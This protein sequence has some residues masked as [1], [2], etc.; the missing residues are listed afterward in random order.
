MEIKVQLS[1]DDSSDWD[2]YVASHPDSSNYHLHGWRYVIER[3]FGH[4][5]YYLVA[6]KGDGSICGVLPLAFMKSA[7]FGKFL[8]SLPFFNYG[9]VLA[10]SADVEQM[11]I[12]GAGRLMAQLCAAHVELRHRET[13]IASLPAKQHKVTMILSLESSAEA[14]WKGFN[15]K[16]RNQIR[17]AE[18]SGLEA[19]FG[20]IELLDGFYEVFTRNMRD[21]GTPVYAKE[22]FRN[23]LNELPEAT[24]IVAV[25]YEGKTIAA[26]IATW[27]RD[28]IE[29]PWASSISDYKSMCP[30]NMLYWEAIKL[31]I[32]KGISWFDFGRSTPDEG[33]FNFKKQ[34]GAKPVQLYWQYLLRDGGRLPELNTKNPKFELAIKVW[35]RLPLML[36]NILGPRI[37]KNIP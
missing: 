16:L 29:I 1:N 17:K 31:A 12:E 7:I 32:E 24:R 6:R 28:T 25:V 9:G 3:S 4:K 33:T 37:V 20:G 11:L 21:L 19:Q 35:Q 36:T 2:A 14:Q 5:T 30:N 26:G 13:S 18:K 8:V 27:F 15:A 23:V 10:D 34:W 22:F